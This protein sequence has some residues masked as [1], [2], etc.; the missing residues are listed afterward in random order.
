MRETLA[1][2]AG[3][4]GGWVLGCMGGAVTDQSIDPQEIDRLKPVIEKEYRTA[5]G[6]IDTVSVRQEDPESLLPFGMDVSTFIGGLIGSGT[7]LAVGRALGRDPDL[8]EEIQEVVA[9]IVGPDGVI[10]R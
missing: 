10:R 3:L 1:I 7:G 8:A 6:Y 5:E 9:K 2:T 4:V